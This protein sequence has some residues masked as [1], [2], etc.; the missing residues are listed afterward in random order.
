MQTFAVAES[1]AGV[2]PLPD[3][4]IPV[5]QQ[6][7]L[8]LIHGI[9]PGLLRQGAVGRPQPA[10]VLVDCLGGALAGDQPI[11]PDRAG[12]VF[13]VGRQPRVLDVNAVL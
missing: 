6:P 1:V 2:L 9:V 7:F 8:G 10:Q 3:R 12:G 4:Q 11:H 5:V 13:R